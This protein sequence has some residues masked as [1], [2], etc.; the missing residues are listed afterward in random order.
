M[1][2]QNKD[3]YNIKLT[4]LNRCKY[5]WRLRERRVD[6]PLAFGLIEIWS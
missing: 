2:L 1:L 4:T 5:N 3:S 6:T